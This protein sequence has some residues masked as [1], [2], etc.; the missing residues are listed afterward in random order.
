MR[1]SDWNSR[2]L[3]IMLNAKFKPE[4]DQNRVAL[5]LAEQQ[6]R[7]EPSTIHVNQI[8]IKNV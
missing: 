6:G 5:R 8:S 7:N 3:R 2:H 1:S 4:I